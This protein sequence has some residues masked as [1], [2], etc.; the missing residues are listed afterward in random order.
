VQE[1]MRRSESQYLSRTLTALALAAGM[2][3]PASATTPAPTTH[4]VV[5]SVVGTSDLHGH[6]EVLPLFGGYLHNLRA[7]RAAEAHPGGVLLVDAGDLFQGTLESNLNEGAA[8]VAAYEALG[9]DAA[10]VGNHEFDYGPVGPAATPLAASDD[11][12]G[13]LKARMAEADFPFLAA[14]LLEGSQ[15]PRW[16]NTQPAVLRTVAGVRVGILGITTRDTLTTTNALNVRGLVLQPLAEAVVREARALRAR[17]AQVIVVAA[18]AGGRCERLD[19]PDDRTSC[20]AGNEAFELAL[21]LPPGLVDVIVAGHRHAGLAHRV[22]DIAIVESFANGRA[23]GR[24][25]V[26]VELPS[27]KVVERDILPP[28]DI[29]PARKSSGPRPTC[30]TDFQRECGAGDYAGRPVLLDPRVAV[31]T[32]AACAAAATA[33][34]RPLGMFVKTPLEKQYD[35]E[36]PLG[37]WIADL[38][39]VARPGADVAIT[40]GGGLRADIAAGPLTYGALHEAQPFDNL[41]ATVRMSAGQVA[42]LLARNLGSDRGVLVVS[43]LRARARCVGAAL[44]VDLFD[45]TGAPIPPDRPL[46]VV[47]SDFLA[48][49][50]DGLEVPADGVVV[51]PGVLIRDGLAAVIERRGGTVDGTDPALFDRSRRR[52]EYPGKRPVVCAPTTP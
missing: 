27:G 33:R 43:G 23:F 41:F 47:T 29:C 26:T 34:A 15:P 46:V 40:N 37:N 44:E 1:R 5:L 18:H 49:G 13:A 4:Q 14:N 30:D 9:Y 50:G 35:R 31:V 11:P 16:P 2:G 51:E 22:N 48:A 6:V 36:S 10:A 8:I 21:V 25:D 3:S 39:R 20:D 7:A 19:D 52:L 32:G 12:R 38:M 45:E 24:V 28:R 17:G 42:R